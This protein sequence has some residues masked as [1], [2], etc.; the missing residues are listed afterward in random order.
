[1]RTL[2]NKFKFECKYFW[3]GWKYRQV[4]HGVINYRPFGVEQKKI[5]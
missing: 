3:N 5:W 1:M 2:A 4:V